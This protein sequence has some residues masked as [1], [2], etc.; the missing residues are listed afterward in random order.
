MVQLTSFSGINLRCIEKVALEEFGRLNVIAGANG[1]GK[2][3]ILEGIYALASGRSFRT[4]RLVKLIR[5]GEDFLRVTGRVGAYEPGTVST[6]VNEESNRVHHIGL[7]RD[8]ERLVIRCDG[9]SINRASDLARL[10]PTLVVRP[11]SYEVLT[12]GRKKDG[13]FWIGQCFT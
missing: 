10:L 11:E 8:R 6:G 13:G 1:A 3:S 5:H 9:E 4:R 2:T 12:G 7:E